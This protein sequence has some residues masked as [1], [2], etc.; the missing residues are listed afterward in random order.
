MKIRRDERETSLCKT[1]QSEVDMEEFRFLSC[2]VGNFMWLVGKIRSPEKQIPCRSPTLIYNLK[3]YWFET[4][5]GAGPG[6]SFGHFWPKLGGA[7][8]PFAALCSRACSCFETEW[9]WL[10]SWVSGGHRLLDEADCSCAV[11]RGVHGRCVPFST[12]RVLQNLDVSWTAGVQLICGDNRTSTGA[13]PSWRTL[14]CRIPWLRVSGV[15]AVKWNSI[16][17]LQPW[18]EEVSEASGSS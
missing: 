1:K 7:P 11:Y 15:R 18:W 10:D 6:V 12:E 13:A 5:A 9:A 3:E 4:G 2:A 14:Q 16:Y 8:G 17:W